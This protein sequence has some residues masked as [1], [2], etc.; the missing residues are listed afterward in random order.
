MENCIF[1]KIVKG[2]I[3]SEVIYED[4]EFLVILDAFPILRG[5][6]LVLTKEHLSPYVFDLGD[7]IY[8]KLMS[9]AKKFAKILDKTFKPIRTGMIIEGLEVPHVHIKLLPLMQN[10]GY[11]LKPIEPHLPKEILKKDADKIRNQIK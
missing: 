6:I 4:K 5:Q 3:P 1:C 11:G 10:S 9:L 2:E 7:V 8:F